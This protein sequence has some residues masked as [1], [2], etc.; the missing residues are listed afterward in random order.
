MYCSC[1]CP[2]I[3]CHGS[4]MYVFGGHDYFLFM[5]EHGDVFLSNVIITYETLAFS[6]FLFR[7]LALSLSS[8]ID[9]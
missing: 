4:A 9:L 7:F 6:F 1:P 2:N 8:H 3:S 5:I